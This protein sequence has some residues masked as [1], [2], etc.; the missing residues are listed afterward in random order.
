MI[1]L[2]VLLATTAAAAG[3]LTARGRP[4]LRLAACWGM[5]VAMGFAGLSHLLMPAPFVQ[6]LPPWV[7]VREELVLATGVLEIVLGAA[8][9]RR[10]PGRRRAGVLLAAYLVLVFPANVYVAVA[11]VE[12]DGMPGASS[13]F[14][15][16]LQLLF[17]AWTLWSTRDVGP[18]VGNDGRATTSPS[19]RS[20]VAA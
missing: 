2:L 3:L 6:H 14:R 18:A 9:L 8:L 11:D 12:V 1:L 19:R 20:D 15:L 10:Q 17:V 16:P 4:S 5:A 7:P 13:W